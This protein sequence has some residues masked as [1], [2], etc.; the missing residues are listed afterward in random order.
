MREAVLLKEGQLYSHVHSR[1]FTRTFAAAETVLISSPRMHR[2]RL[3]ALV[4][5]VLLVA[6]S[7]SYTSG[8][9]GEVEAS[10]KR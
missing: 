9:L 4:L 2:R 8:N 5:L 3:I 7:V 10:L 6:A 1:I